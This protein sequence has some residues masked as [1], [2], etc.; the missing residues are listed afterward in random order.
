MHL[1]NAICLLVMLAAGC[2][3]AGKGVPIEKRPTP[4]QPNETQSRGGETPPA[5]PPAELSAEQ[6]ASRLSVVAS[7]TMVARAAVIRCAGRKLLPD[8]EGVY[9][10][11]VQLLIETRTAIAREDL[12]RAESLARRARQ[13]SVSLTC[14]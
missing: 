9:E 12:Q 11:T 3:T 13:M 1:R 8:Q 5:R 7:D 2:A 14:R 10:A 4:P 6:R